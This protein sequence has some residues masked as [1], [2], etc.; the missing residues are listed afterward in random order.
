MMSHVL[1]E[2]VL[3]ATSAA[4]QM[5]KHRIK[6][7]IVLVE[8]VSGVIANKDLILTVHKSTKGAVIQ[9]ARSLAME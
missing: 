5:I 3:A 1:H 6:G 8:S 4:R 2:R 9:L 7:S